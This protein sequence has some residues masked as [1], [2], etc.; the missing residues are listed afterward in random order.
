MAT[1]INVSA[2]TAYDARAAA[3]ARRRRVPLGRRLRKHGTGYLFILGA[4]VCFALFSWW[5]M[6]REVIMSFQKTN[7]A[8][9][10]KWVGFEN[11]RHVF[12]DPDFWAAWRMSG[13]F[14]L[15]ALVLGF[16]VPLAIA[17]VLNEMRH[18]KGY[19]RLL[20]YLPVMLPPVAGAFLWRWFYQ[21][22]DSGL[23]NMVLHDLH[24]P[25]IQWFQSSH[26]LAVLCLVLFSTWA[27]MGSSVLIYLAALQG[28]PGE[29]YEAAELDGASI[30]K[31]VRHVTLP[32]LKLIISLMLMLQ[33]VNTMQVFL[34]PDAISH[35]VNGT[36]SVVYQIYDYAFSSLNFGNAAALGILLMLVLMI[37]SGIYLKLARSVE[38]D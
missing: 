21:S 38:E 31:R 15:F 7:F 14:T 23:F 12:A 26:E 11:Y 25:T 10:T 8:G 3:R 1:T 33:V 20:V 27:N 2:A 28:V 34:E 18:A 9:Q 22:D 6:V 17:V 32:Q 19:F 37:F 36:V 16:A 5:P 30:L 35:G 13:L 29:L 4:A 24:L